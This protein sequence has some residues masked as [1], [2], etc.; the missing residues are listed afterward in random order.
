MTPNIDVRPATE[1]D[2]SQWNGFLHSRYGANFY[3]RFE[4][5]YV[6]RDSLGHRTHYLLAEHDSTVVGVLPLVHI[7]SRLFGHVICSA[8]FVNFGGAAA[9]DDAGQSRLIEAAC[10]HA[11]DSGCDYLEIRSTKPIEGLPQRTDKVSM[12]VELRSDPEELFNAF[13]AKH[14]RNVRVAL[15][16]AIVVRSGGAELLDDFYAVLSDSWH[17]LGTPMYRKKY[18]ADILRHFGE[19]VRIFVAYHEGVAIATAFNGYYR[20]TVEGMW[21]GV[22]QASRELQPNYVLYWE[23]MR[24]ACVR[25]FQRYH[26][27]RSTKDSGATAFK[28]KWLAVPTQ[29]YWNYYLVR[30]KSVPML[31]PSNP[32]YEMAIK[33]WQRAP[34][35]LVQLVGPPLARLIP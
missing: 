19:D 8:P 24:D 16:A 23:M 13:S 29:L 21:A 15:K 5:A 10:A 18:F 30:A 27:G 22:T 35:A 4:W 2:S 26:L 32:K 34:R 1:L 25:G 12:T 31:S 9:V 6:N 28:E 7:R 11:R 33:L 3:Q 17:G 14:R 20:G